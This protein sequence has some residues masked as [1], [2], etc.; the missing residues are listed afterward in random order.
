MAPDDRLIHLNSETDYVRGITTT[1]EILRDPMGHVYHKRRESKDGKVIWCCKMR[2]AEP[3]GTH[4]K[5]KAT[6]IGPIL[7]SILNNHNHPANHK[8]EIKV[9]SSF[10]IK[11]G[12]CGEMGIPQ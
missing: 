8:K 4:C 7:D 1:G 3:N 11:I 2:K 6:T 5:A 12:R 10:V 9:S